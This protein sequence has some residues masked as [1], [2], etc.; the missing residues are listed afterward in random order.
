MPLEGHKSYRC[1]SKTRRLAASTPIRRVCSEGDLL[2]SKVVDNLNSQLARGFSAKM[3]AHS[4][5]DAEQRIFL[6]SS[7]S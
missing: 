4:V 6:I 1:L 5:S 2:E 3:P 7:A